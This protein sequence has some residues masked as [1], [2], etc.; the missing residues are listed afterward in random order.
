MTDTSPAQWPEGFWAIPLQNSSQVNQ[1]LVAETSFFKTV[2]SDRSGDCAAHER[3]STSLSC[4][5]NHSVTSLGVFMVL[6]WR[7]LNTWTVAAHTVTLSYVGQTEKMDSSENNTC[8]TLSTVQDL[9]CWHQCNPTFGIGTSY[10]RLGYCS[11]TMN[12]DPMELP[13]DSFGENRSW[14]AH[15]ILQGFG[16]LWFYVFAYNLG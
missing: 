10:Q 16:Q 3:C 9:H 1:M 5:S 7:S 8:F 15:L 14:G 2:Q 6:L 4:S 11:P 12:I 13:T